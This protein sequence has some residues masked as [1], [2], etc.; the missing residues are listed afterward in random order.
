MQTEDRPLRGIEFPQAEQK[1]VMHH[2]CM[3]FCNYSVHTSEVN[4]VDI[5]LGNTSSIA[6]SKILIPIA[7]DRGSGAAEET[8]TR[9][10]ITSTATQLLGLRHSAF[11]AIFF[12]QK[13]KS[14]FTPYIF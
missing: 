6:Y 8:A 9:E 2:R 12:D 11:L 1:K 5:S 10:V 13:L 3:K 14:K 7:T 4:V